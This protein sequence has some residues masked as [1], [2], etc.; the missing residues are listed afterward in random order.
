MVQYINK[1]AWQDAELK[2]EI[3]AE[4]ADGGVPVSVSWDDVEGKPAVIAAGADQAAARTAIGAGTGT[5]NLAVGSTAGAAPG[6]AAPGVATTA[7][8]SDHVHPVQT[9]VSGLAGSATVLATAR[10]FSLS[11]DVTAAAVSFNGSA[12]VNLVTSLAPGVIV[13]ADV[14]VTAGIAL[15]KLEDVAAGTDG[16]AAGTL[17]ATLQALATRIAALETP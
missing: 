12:V 9:T 15:T 8:R 17:Q 2:E 10:N 11:G 14:S 3:L 13:N 7:A 4:I 16:L 5:S 1:A 6:T